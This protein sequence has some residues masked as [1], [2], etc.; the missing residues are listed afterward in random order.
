MLPFPERSSS[1]LCRPSP[2]G[3]LFASHPI[4]V[5]DLVLIAATIFLPFFSLGCRLPTP[6]RTIHCRCYP[7]VPTVTL[8]LSSSTYS[9]ALPP[10]PCSLFLPCSRLLPPFFHFRLPARIPSRRLPPPPSYVAFFFKIYTCKIAFL[11][12]FCVKK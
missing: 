12:L 2:E 3:H 4:A 1:S 11:S 8:L 6:T 10:P 7:F 9:H 5:T